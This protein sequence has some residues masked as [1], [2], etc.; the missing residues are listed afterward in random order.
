MGICAWRL[1]DMVVYKPKS[2][3]FCPIK[4]HTQVA[5]DIDV[6]VTVH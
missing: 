5:E 6:Q 1:L 3:N 4:T 2:L